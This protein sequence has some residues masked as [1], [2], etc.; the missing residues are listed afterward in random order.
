MIIYICSPY[1]GETPEQVQKHLEYARELTRE[2][3]LAGH[4]T[5][6]PHLSIAGCLDDS[7]ELE[8]RIGLK[9]GLE[10]LEQCDAVIAGVRHGISEGMQGEIDLAEELAIPIYYRDKAE[11]QAAKKDFSA[12]CD[13]DDENQ[14]NDCWNCSHFCFPIGCMFYEDMKEG[15]ADGAG[16]A[17]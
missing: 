6:T 3:L 17:I 7:D 11:T 1:R 15:G 5:I 10:L 2:A 13:K 12:V 16:K 8:R 9:A 4:S 14:E